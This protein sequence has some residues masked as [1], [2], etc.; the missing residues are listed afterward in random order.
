MFCFCFLLSIKFMQ[1]MPCW[2]S[3][4]YQ[5]PML[6]FRVSG[7]LISVQIFEMAKFE[8]L[9]SLSINMPENELNEIIE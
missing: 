4:R 2:L 1:G 8:I 7:W 5:L 3:P 9:R 6:N